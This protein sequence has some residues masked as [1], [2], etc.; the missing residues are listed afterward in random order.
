MLCPVF[1]YN[2]KSRNKEDLCVLRK[3]FDSS[4]YAHVDYEIIDVKTS[5]KAEGKFGIS[6]IS[7][8]NYKTGRFM[9]WAKK[10]EYKMRPKESVKWPAISMA[11]ASFLMIMCYAHDQ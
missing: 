8:G 11:Q 4:C 1:S 5:G 2:G 6:E 7:F 3:Y 9:N 10:M